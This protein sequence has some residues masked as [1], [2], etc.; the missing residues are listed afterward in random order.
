MTL[1]SDHP[2][3]LKPPALCYFCAHFRWGD[4]FSLEPTPARC[5]AFPGGIPQEILDNVADHRKPH[6]GDHGLQFALD[7]RR[8]ENDIA[9]WQQ[10]RADELEDME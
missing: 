5:E 10:D 7:P 4:K 8:T 6:A 3:K 9:E 1:T 2:V